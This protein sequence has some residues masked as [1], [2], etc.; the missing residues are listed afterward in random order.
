MELCKYF[1]DIITTR[2]GKDEEQKLNNI[3]MPFSQIDY[4]LEGPDS[5]PCGRG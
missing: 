5:G 3:P 1:E 2:T 4:F